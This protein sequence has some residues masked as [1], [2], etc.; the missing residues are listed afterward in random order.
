MAMKTKTAAKVFKIIFRY[1]PISAAVCTLCSLGYALCAAFS[2]RLM[3]EL[4]VEAE[5]LCENTLSH[6]LLLAACYLMVQIVRHVFNLVQDVCWNVGVEE[7]CK[8]QFQMLLSEKAASL[9]Y[10]DFED[11]KKHD[12]VARAREC[13]DS[14]AVTQAYTNLLALTESV[15][16]V[17]GLLWAMMAYSVWYLP[18]MLLSVAPY[19]ISRIAAGKEFYTLRWFQAPHIRKR[20]YFYSL[21]TS[22]AFQKE[23]RVFGF[24]ENFRRHWEEQREQTAQETLLFKI[25]DSGRLAWCEALI[26][27][28]YIAGILL[29]LFLVQSGTI[30]IGVFGAGIYSF[31]TAQNS[32][33]ILFS[34]HGLLG[35]NL[36]QAGDLFALLDLEEEAKRDLA[37]SKLF[38]EIHMKDVSFTYP[39]TEAPALKIDEL[40]IPAGERVVVVGENGSGK[41]TLVK[42]LTGLY[43]PDTGMAYYDGNDLNMISRN[44]LSE[45]IGA[46]SQDYVSYHLSIRDNVGIRSPK[47]VKS[48]ERI[49]NALTEAGLAPPRN[50][51]AW[52]GREFGGEELSG[53]QWQRLA[54]AGILCKNCEVIFLDEPTSAL[55]PN[56]EYDILKHFIDISAHKTAIIVSHRVGLCPLADKIVFMQ[57]GAVRAVGTHQNLLKACAEYQHFYQE[58]AKWYVKQEK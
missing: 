21:F 53:G 50:L 10:I 45:L 33:Q 15:F 6:V 17:V 34:L 32:T 51:D 24:G 20:K 8:H 27:V 18:V 40:T 13:V 52:L 39:N 9:P 38:S 41:S 1:A 16:T 36:L 42:L 3:A 56:A 43:A 44:S 57:K 55:D 4:L 14:M 31:R 12:R 29:S 28:G 23:Q 22:P 7:R 30:A 54:I 47:A 37:I 35:E 48:D 5:T 25:K 19:L 2:V 49:R 11:E 58:Q 26:T 46:L